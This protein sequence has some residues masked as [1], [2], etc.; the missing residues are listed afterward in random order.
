MWYDEIDMDY[1]KELAKYSADPEN[2]YYTS[3]LGRL[4]MS[5]GIKDA[6]DLRRAI[7]EPAIF[8]VIPAS[9]LERTDISSTE[10]IVYGEIL[11]LSRRSGICFATNVHISQTLGI[12]ERTIRISLS[13]LVKVGLV[14]VQLKRGKK[15]TYRNIELVGYSREANNAPP[16]GN[17]EPPREEKNAA[18]TISRNIQREIYKES[19]TV[20]HFERFWQAYPKKVSKKSALKAWQKV[21]VSE[22]TVPKILSALEAQVSTEQWRKDGGRFI[23]H[24]T[25]WINQERWNDEVRVEIPKKVGKYA[26]L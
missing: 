1:E 17:F 18:L 2:V 5:L 23:P 22:E 15:G 19:K 7:T 13:N 4:V 24:P 6:G 9:I 21:V 14:K 8:V 12:A 3:I 26:N 16:G 11:A 10:K 25:T 20:G